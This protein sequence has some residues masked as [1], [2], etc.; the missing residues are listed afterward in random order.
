MFSSL[1]GRAPSPPPSPTL[2]TS[3]MFAKLRQPVDDMIA[4]YNA[5]QNNNSTELGASTIEIPFTLS[6]ILQTTLNKNRFNLNMRDAWDCKREI[7]TVKEKSPL[8][9]DETFIALKETLDE[10][11]QVAN[12]N[13]H[14]QIDFHRSLCNF[15]L[16]HNH[17]SRDKIL[18]E[19]RTRLNESLKFINDDNTEKQHTWKELEDLYHDME[20]LKE[21]IDELVPGEIENSKKHIEEFHKNLYSLESWAKALPKITVGI[22]T[23]NC[24]NENLPPEAVDQLKEQVEKLDT[25]LVFFSFQEAKLSLMLVE[26]LVKRILKRFPE[27]TYTLLDYKDIYTP[28]HMNPFIFLDEAVRNFYNLPRA[29]VGILYK[30]ARFPDKNLSTTSFKKHTPWKLRELKFNFDSK[31]GMFNKLTFPHLDNFQINFIGA[32]LDSEDYINGRRQAEALIKYATQED[33]KHKSITFTA[34]DFNIR[35]SETYV[36]PEHRQKPA[37]FDQLLNTDILR[38]NSGSIQE[39]QKN[40]PLLQRLSVVPISAETY[41]K[42]DHNGNVTYNASRKTHDIG[43]LD[44]IGYINPPESHATLLHKN[45]DVAIIEPKN[46]AGRVISDHKVVVAKFTALPPLTLEEKARFRECFRVTPLEKIHTILHESQHSDLIRTYLEFAIEATQSTENNDPVIP[47]HLSDIG[48][49]KSDII[50][51]I[52]HLYVLLG[53]TVDTRLYNRLIFGTCEKI[54]AHEN[55]NGQ[56]I[57]DRFNQLLAVEN[58]APLVKS[59]LL[60]PFSEWL[61]ENKIARCYYG[62]RQNNTFF[63]HESNPIRSNSPIDNGW[64]YS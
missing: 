42:K 7:D 39:W 19:A 48:A 35:L 31:G 17:A 46:K 11:R 45:E 58:V 34:G 47:Y 36:K 61:D 30:N 53:Q 8:S 37:Q 52:D 21:R 64:K 25:D 27:N 3:D 60:K 23:Y 29:K 20:I 5:V 41:C 63:T 15:M 50:F 4:L 12:F 13:L 10:L 44:I 6:N 24:G 32:H 18:R 43:P 22:M 28:T 16:K 26:S 38:A 62:V 40:S 56:F 55:D 59:Y 9:E 33:A 51:I 49:I 57:Q 14:Q 1:F 2:V 54:L